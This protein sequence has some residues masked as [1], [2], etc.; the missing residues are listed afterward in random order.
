MIGV[1]FLTYD[2]AIDS[3]I[4]NINGGKV[5]FKCINMSRED[6]DK[7]T[8]NRTI[9]QSQYDRIKEILSEGE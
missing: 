5:P 9:N 8:R 2:I 1:A 6:N 4:L 3:H 7:L